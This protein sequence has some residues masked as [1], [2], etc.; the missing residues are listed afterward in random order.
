MLT[1]L[2]NY[3]FC[4]IQLQ[5]KHHFMKKLKVLF[6]TLTFASLCTQCHTPPDW[7]G[8][9][10]GCDQ[11]EQSDKDAYTRCKD[12]AFNTLV[13]Q[14]EVCL[15]KFENADVSRQCILL[16]RDTYKRAID[17]CDK[18]YFEAQLKWKKCW[19]DCHQTSIGES[20]QR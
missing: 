20:T 7:T 1:R 2:H 18:T 10:T 9:L 4:C 5:L 15:E 12:E 16:A 6:I 14:Q 13:R 19:I 8:C 17:E 3:D 11:L